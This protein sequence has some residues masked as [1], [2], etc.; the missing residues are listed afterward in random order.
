[1]RHR[2]T[3]TLAARTL[4]VACMVSAGVLLGP[5]D[6]DRS[7]ARREHQDVSSRHA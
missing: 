1:M 7:H 6:S 5:S 3:K 4:T 2:I